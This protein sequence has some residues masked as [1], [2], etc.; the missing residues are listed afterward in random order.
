M[1]LPKI[2]V[3]KHSLKIFMEEELDTLFPMDEVARVVAH[4]TRIRRSDAV[5]EDGAP[6]SCAMRMS[7]IQFPTDEKDDGPRQLLIA[8]G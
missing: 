4:P 5:G 6:E 3:V 7:D 1:Q 2:T 8:V